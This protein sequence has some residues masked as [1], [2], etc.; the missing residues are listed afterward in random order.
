MGVLGSGREG[1][2][3]TV[4]RSGDYVSTSTHVQYTRMHMIRTNARHALAAAADL[5]DE[6]K[7]IAK[8]NKKATT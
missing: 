3:V 4:V 5:D 7:R 2:Q 6:A 8:K 1:T